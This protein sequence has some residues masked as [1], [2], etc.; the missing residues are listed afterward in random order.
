MTTEEAARRLEDMLRLEPNWDSYN[1]L[2]VSRDAVSLMRSLVAMSGFPT[3][4]HLAA[5]GDGNIGFEFADGID[6]ETDMARNCIRVL[7]SRDPDTDWWTWP[8]TTY[9]IGDVD[10][11]KRLARDVALLLTTLQ[12]DGGM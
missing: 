6:A 11:Y 12:P 7:D 5:M 8:I 1:G 9:K 2:P 10:E 3:L 4:T